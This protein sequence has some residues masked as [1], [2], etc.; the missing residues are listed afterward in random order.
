MPEQEVIDKS[1]AYTGN[2][3][4]KGAITKVSMNVPMQDQ[5]NNNGDNGTGAQANAGEVLNDAEKANIAAGLNKD[6]TKNDAGA[7]LT[8]EIKAANI[9]KGLNEDGTTKSTDLTKEQKEA[10]IKNGLNEDG[11]AKAAEPKVFSDE[12][13]KAEYEKRFPTQPTLTPEEIKKKE[14]AFE[15]RMLDFYV[16]KGGKI[17][18]F[19][20]LKQVAGADLTDLTKA[21]LH[22]ELKDAGFND[23]E[24]ALVQ[25]ERYF[26]MEQAEIDAIEDPEEKALAQKK[27]DYGKKKLEGRGNAQKAAA[28]EFFNTLKEAVNLSDSDAK[29]ESEFTSNVEDYFSKLERKMTLQLGKVDDTDIAPVEFEVPEDIIKAAKEELKN[30]TSRK[31]LL[32]NTDG[33]LNH[34]NIAELVL[35]AKMFDSAAKTSYLT[36]ATREVEKFEKIFPK[37]A[38][39]LGVGGNNQAPTGKPG[40][41]VKAGEVQRF[42]QAANQ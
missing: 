37:N 33:F 39:A 29:K 38:N 41:L 12:E 32:F 13:L 36:G 25:K 22:K 19:A 24:I 2:T 17:E 7:E 9:A 18:E 10:N 1:K 35:K 31:Q 16:E 27:L 30:V 8:P 14:D 11:T 3:V 42:R 26:Q 5:I 34:K 15:K 6:G 4:S 20:L 21:E 23:A 40:K 28:T